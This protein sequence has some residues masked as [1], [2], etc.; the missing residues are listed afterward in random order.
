M[1]LR[2]KLCI[3]GGPL[4]GCDVGCTRLKAARLPERWVEHTICGAGGGQAS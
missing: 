2:A 1:A 4:P 3:P